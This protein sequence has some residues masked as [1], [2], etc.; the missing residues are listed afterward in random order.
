MPV[1]QRPPVRIQRPPSRLRI[2]LHGLL[3]WAALLSALLALGLVS[4]YVAME[5]TMEKDRVEVPRVTGLDTAGAGELLKESELVPRVV[6]EEFNAK[7]PKGH[8]SAQR[9]VAGTRAK[10]G[11][12]VR[13]ILSRGTDQLEVPSLSG[14]GFPQA[15]RMLAEAGLTLG[16]VLRIHDDGH[17]QDTIIAQDPPPGAAATRGATVTVLVSAGS[18]EEDVTLPDMRGRDV[19]SA[20]NLLKE[21][22][23]EGRVTFERAASREGRVISQTPAPGETVKA[24]GQ[25]QIVVGD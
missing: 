14:V 20:L 13:L 4:G 15:Q 21:L 25:V 5:V 19:V 12:E 22:Q 23:V 24:G 3:K 16:R 17:L 8:V 1:P 18:W 7:V 6:A 11:S 9:P 2:L 10:R